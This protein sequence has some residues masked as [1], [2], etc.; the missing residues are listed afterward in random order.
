[1]PCRLSKR[2]Q[3]EPLEAHPGLNVVRFGCRSI[4]RCTG[5]KD[6]WSSLFLH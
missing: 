2:I 1:M 5:P 3:V 6:L 4:V